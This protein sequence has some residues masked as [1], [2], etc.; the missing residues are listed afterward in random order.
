MPTDLDGHRVPPALRRVLMDERWEISKLWALDLPVEHV[1]T[2]SL[3]WQLDLPWWR[4]GEEW[5]AVTPNE[6]RD[7]PYG[8]L[9]WQWKRT[10]AADLSSR[11][12]LRW[13]E[14]RLVILDG[15]HRLLKA[16]VLG[17]PTMAA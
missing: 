12:D 13:A 15:V 1:P 4:A 10:L 7:A 14:N 2:A 5:F 17:A 8:P 9:Q 3:A 6:V 16:V 11:I